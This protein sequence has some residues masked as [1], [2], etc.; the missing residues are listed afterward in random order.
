MDLNNIRSPRDL[1]KLKIKELEGICGDIRA[2]L[3]SAVSKTGGHLASNLGVVELTVALHTVFNAPAD[4]I[5][6]DVGHQS[7][8]HKILTGRARQFSELRRKNGLSGFPKSTESPC[9]AFNTGHASTSI[10]AAAGYCA[11]RDIQRAKYNVV[12]VIGDGSMTGGLAYEAINNAGRSDSK[13]LVILNDNQMSISENVGALSRYLNEVRTAPAYI[14]AK[15][16]INK[17]LNRI[18]VVGRRLKYFIERTKDGIKYLLAPGGIF[19]ELGFT[20][21]GPVDGHN[22]KDLIGVL[23]KVKKMDGPVLLHV[24]T[25]KG[26]GYDQAEVSPE[27][28]HGVD[29]FNVETGKPV[30]LKQYDAYSDVFGKVLTGLAEKHP[31]LT[32]ITAAMPVGVGL[33]GFAGKFPGR[34]FDVGIAE[35]HAVTFA[36]GL[37]KGG[38]TPVVAIY[39]TFLQRAFDQILHDV[40]MQNLHVVF[41][42]DRAGVVGADGETH[43]GL[44]DISFLWLPNM[45]ILAPINER[46]MVDMIKFAIFHTGPIAIRYPKGSVSHVFTDRV[47]PVV[48]GKSDIIRGG[49]DFVILAVGSMMDQAHQASERL[50][51]LGYNPGLINVRFVKPIDMDMVKS[52]SCYRSVFV[53]EEHVL[54]GGFG[55]KLLSALNEVNINAGCIHRFALPDIFVEHGSRSEILEQY[56]LDYVSITD[57]I[58]KLI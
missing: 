20:Y 7:Y 55:S 36:A 4:K 31:N 37:A 41:A 56:G 44:F 1:K 8:V 57:R 19:E 42:V 33:G 39:S 30:A 54:S 13:L 32:A 47:K 10:S 14:G 48:Y 24:Y 5:I 27:E 43:Q 12:A 28:F 29:S 11:A 52:L 17:I 51:T 49:E 16:D 9:D 18:P 25:I 45:T 26:K 3:I 34:L 35:A 38:L 15:A 22:L 53:L 2:F 6:W 46:E 21:I 23:Q 58:L 50:K 40:C